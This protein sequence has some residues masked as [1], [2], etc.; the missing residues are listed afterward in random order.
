LF[1]VLISGAGG[2]PGAIA[3]GAVSPVSDLLSG[4]R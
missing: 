3:R 4:S 2:A 1:M